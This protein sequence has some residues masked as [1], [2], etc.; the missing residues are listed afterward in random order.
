M[1][2][3]ENTCLHQG[4][5]SFFYWIFAF[6]FPAEPAPTVR[7]SGKDP[8]ASFEASNMWLSKFTHRYGISKQKKKIRKVSQ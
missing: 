7:S 2:V 5:Y 6:F 3:L 8:S 4:G 1:V